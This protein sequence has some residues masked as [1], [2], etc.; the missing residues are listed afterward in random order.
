M[1]KYV[2]PEVFYIGGSKDVTVSITFLANAHDSD[3]LSIRNA[4]E[5]LA[6]F[7]NNNRTHKS[8]AKKIEVR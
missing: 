3:I 8:W 4:A 7:A 6:F 1:A 2:N 5:A